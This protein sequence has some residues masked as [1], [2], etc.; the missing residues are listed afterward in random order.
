MRILL[1][2]P[3][4]P[5]QAITIAEFMFCEPL[6]LEAVY[7]VLQEKHSV[8]ILD[9]MAEQVDIVRYLQEHRP[10]AVGITALC[11]DVAHVLELART[12]K[13][14]DASIPVVVGGTQA[15]LM[16]RAFADQAVDYVVQQSTTAGLHALFHAL[17]V[18][19]GERTDIPGVLSV[20][21]GIPQ[22]I[23]LQKNEYLVP[24]RRSCEQ[25][26]NQYSYFVYRPCALL[27]TSQGCSGCCTFCLR[28]RL[29]GCNEV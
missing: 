23:S 25:Y 6:G 17:A 27:Q 10:E 8:S 1:I 20:Q 5:P 21:A 7:A 12:V 22:H 13:A 16:P 11:I 15:Q 24:D 18:A 28:W 9:M 4:R 14:V 2:R 3:P 29:E 26:R 19:E